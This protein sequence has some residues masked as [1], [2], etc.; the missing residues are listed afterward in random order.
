MVHIKKMFY[1]NKTDKTFSPTNASLQQPDT[2]GS[3]ELA[4]F[5][6]QEK[7]RLHEIMQSSSISMDM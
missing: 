6:L 2:S 3:A 4:A 5:P 7:T 1:S